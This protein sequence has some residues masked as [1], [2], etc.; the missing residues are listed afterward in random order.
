MSPKKFTSEAKLTRIRSAVYGG[1]VQATNGDS[2]ALRR[3]DRRGRMGTRAARRGAQP[4][5]ARGRSAGTASDFRVVVIQ[6]TSASGH[7]TGMPT[8]CLNARGTVAE[9]LV[10]DSC[11]G[12]RLEILERSQPLRGRQRE[13][14]RRL[15]PPRTTIA[16]RF[17]SGT[18]AKCACSNSARDSASRCWI[19]PWP[20]SLGRLST[21]T[22]KPRSGADRWLPENPGKTRR[23]LC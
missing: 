18:A 1:V 3:R 5:L 7:F 19:C 14:L 22:R 8:R 10:I 21:S 11:E 23:S 2:R 20:R 9:S 15:A 12:A 16:T 13:S 4:W 17:A 6:G